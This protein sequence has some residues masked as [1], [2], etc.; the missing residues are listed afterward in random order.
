MCGSVERSPN[1]PYQS[2]T[3]DNG[4]CFQ[5]SLRIISGPH[6]GISC[7]A[8][9]TPNKLFFLTEQ[10]T[11]KNP[12]MKSI[13]PWAKLNIKIT[14]IQLK[15]PHTLNMIMIQ[16]IIMQVHYNHDVCII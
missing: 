6:V 1:R 5:W 13:H 14:I 2:L 4:R 16:T 7:I 9:F 11:V 12:A 15:S 3:I 8:K 10:Y